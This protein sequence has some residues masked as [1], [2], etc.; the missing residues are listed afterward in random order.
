MG[1]LKGK[2]DQLPPEYQKEVN[3]FIDF[4]LEKRLK[5]VVSGK[6]YSNYS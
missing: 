2:I 6:K 5:A 3:D 4:L 1:S